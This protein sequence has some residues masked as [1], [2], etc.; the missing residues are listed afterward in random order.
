MAKKT[1]EKDKDRPLWEPD[2]D[3]EYHLG[4]LMYRIEEL[5]QKDR[6]NAR[7]TTKN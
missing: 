1:K 3:G 4:D 7:K 2:A 5:K 6:E